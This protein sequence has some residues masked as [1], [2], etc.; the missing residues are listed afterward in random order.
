M[1]TWQRLG[2]WLDCNTGST[3]VHIV[4]GMRNS[5]VRRE[6]FWFISNES[7]LA[8]IMVAITSDWQL[9]LVVIDAHYFVKGR[10]QRPFKLCQKKKEHKFSCFVSLLRSIK[11]C[12]WMKSWQKV[13]FKY[14]LVMH[15]W[16]YFAVLGNYSIGLWRM[17][18]LDTLAISF[19]L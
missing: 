11:V 1:A 7:L 3:E 8:V 2:H 5:S 18:I 12:H 4:S 6:I 14:F 10:R 9:I 15:V 16:A 13:T 19:F 17:M